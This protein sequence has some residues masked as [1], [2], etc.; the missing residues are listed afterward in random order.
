MSFFFSLTALKLNAGPILLV[1]VFVSCW[2]LVFSSHV[3]HTVIKNS[4]TT[5]TVAA[6]AAA[7]SAEEEI[8]SNAIDDDKWPPKCSGTWSLLGVREWNGTNLRCCESDGMC[9]GFN[10]QT[11]EKLVIGSLKGL[12]NVTSRHLPTK[13]TFTFQRL[14]TFS[15]LFFFKI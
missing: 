11:V 6:V 3:H 9:H 14:A 2:E 13:N 10:P 1:L 7:T 8:I 4:S 5:A 12:L 15:F